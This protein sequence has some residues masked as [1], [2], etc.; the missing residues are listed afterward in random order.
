[1][2]TAIFSDEES[3][4]LPSQRW[5]QSVIPGCQRWMQSVIPGAILY[6]YTKADTTSP[7]A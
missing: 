7:T 5:M 2:P 3:N 6:T 1:M 4:N